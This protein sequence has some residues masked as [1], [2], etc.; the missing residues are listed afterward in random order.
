VFARALLDGVHQFDAPTEPELGLALDLGEQYADS[1]VDLT[2]L[3]VMAM[4]H[5]RDAAIFTWDFRHF[6]SVILERGHHWRLLVE[7]HELPPP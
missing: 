3:T 5:T 4:A 6:R 1:G 7:E 2:D